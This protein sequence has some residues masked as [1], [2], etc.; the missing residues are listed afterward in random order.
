MCDMVGEGVV[1]WVGGGFV[2][3]GPEGSGWGSWSTFVR[4][5]STYDCVP[6]HASGTAPDAC[7]HD[8]ADGCVQGNV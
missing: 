6:G 3:H 4:W 7:A 8:L 5:G 1:G 2:G